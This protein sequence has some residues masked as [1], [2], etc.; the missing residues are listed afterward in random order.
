MFTRTKHVAQLAAAAAVLLLLV[1]CGQQS[2]EDVIR[3]FNKAIEKG[4]KE[5]VMN[6]LHP[7]T[8]AMLSERKV[9][10]MVDLQ[11]EHMKG[12]GG[13]KAMDIQLEGDDKF[14]RGK[15]TTTFAGNCPAKTETTGATKFDDKWRVGGN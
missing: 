2:P 3:D 9:G 10:A 11:R 1:A 4:D 5:K 12:C 8:L 6:L 15:L 14:K 13:I 7:A